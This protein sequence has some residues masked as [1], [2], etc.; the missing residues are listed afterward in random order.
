M[1]DDSI[2]IGEDFL[3]HYGVKGMHWGIRKH[4]RLK[5]VAGG[6]TAAMVTAALF[7]VSMPVV[8][9]AGTAGALATRAILDGRG[10]T[11]LE[12]IRR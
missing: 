10:H 5:V 4:G 7:P 8:F 1:S 6:V 11:S 9:L 12:E 3:Q 2:D